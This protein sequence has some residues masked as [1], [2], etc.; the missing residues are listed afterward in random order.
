MDAAAVDRLMTMGAGA[1]YAVLA[2]D[3]PTV[4]AIADEIK[5]LGVPGDEVALWFST[6]AAVILAKALGENLATWHVADQVRDAV[7]IEAERHFR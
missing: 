3:S 5:R 4:A 6:S 1:I 7:R 2:D